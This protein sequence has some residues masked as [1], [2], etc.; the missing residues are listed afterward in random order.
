MRLLLSLHRMATPGRIVSSGGNEHVTAPSPKAPFI[1]TVDSILPEKLPTAQ[2]TPP[3]DGP[4]AK[5]MS[6]QVIEP[7]GTRASWT[8]SMCPW[9]GAADDSF[10]RHHKY[11]FE[12]GNVVFL[13]R[14][15][16]LCVVL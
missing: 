14:G 4:R 5:Y 6:S 8:S 15:L 7:S 12:D 11:F 10:V 2:N 13:V 9:V 3:A 16:Q 1:V